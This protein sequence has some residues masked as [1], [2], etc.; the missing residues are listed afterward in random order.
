[1]AWQNVAGSQPEH[2]LGK[3]PAHAFDDPIELCQRILAIHAPQDGIAGRLKR[4]MDARIQLG[5]AGLPIGRFVHS[6]GLEA[7]L[8]AAIADAERRGLPDLKPLLDALA[9]A[10][11]AL[12]EADFN[13]RADT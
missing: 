11:A 1:M 8:R 10:T 5:D 2:G 3:T 6:H 13:A 7:W 4:Q 12:R 9:R